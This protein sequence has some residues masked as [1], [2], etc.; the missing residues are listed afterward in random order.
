MVDK[1]AAAVACAL[2]K[3]S[4]G[5]VLDVEDTLTAFPCF[6][7]TLIVLRSPKHFK[8]SALCCAERSFCSASLINC[9]FSCHPPPPPGSPQLWRL[10]SA[11]A[12]PLLLNTA[13]RQP[14]GLLLGSCCW[15]RI[16]HTE[17]LCFPGLMTGTQLCVLLFSFFV[18]SVCHFGCHTEGFGHLILPSQSGN[19]DSGELVLSDL[20][21]AF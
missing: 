2:P 6:Y 15:N 11:W 5:R 8:H 19:R 4:W 3:P 9:F 17:L 14:D 12:Q 16:L 18:F 10:N 13:C 20:G 1:K 7:S 21:F